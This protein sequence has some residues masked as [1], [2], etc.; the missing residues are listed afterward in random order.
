MLQRVF[1][2]GP[3]AVSWA[4]S[5]AARHQ[6]TSALA[7]RLTAAERAPATA[8]TAANQVSAGDATWARR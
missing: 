2:S 1:P 3:G 7:A 6:A 4:R 5:Y 8:A